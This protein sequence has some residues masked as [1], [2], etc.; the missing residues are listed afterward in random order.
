[1]KIIADTNVLLRSIVRDD[2]AQAILADAALRD[3]SQIVLTLQTL[4]EFVWILTTRYRRPR[5][6]IAATIRTLMMT[7]NVVADR[8]AV[9]DGL[10]I[11]D[12]GGDFADGIINA[13]GLRLGGNVYVTFDVTAADILAAAGNDVTLLSTSP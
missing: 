6:D 5:P 8:R 7:P 1:M 12:A 11:M 4:C 13:E 9:D 3:A 2:P 10:A